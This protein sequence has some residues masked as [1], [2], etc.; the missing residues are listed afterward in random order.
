M[1]LLVDTAV[2]AAAA[3]LGRP[4]RSALTSLGIALGVTAL[5]AM[6]GMGA[7]SAASIASEFEQLQ[8]TRVEVS[9]PETVPELMASL[10]PGGLQRAADLNGVRAVGVVVTSGDRPVEV[11]QPPSLQTV[12]VPLIAG[13]GEMLEAERV[14]VVAGRS[15]DAGHQ[16]RGDRVALLGVIAARRVGLTPDRLPSQLRVGHEVFV[17]GGIVDSPDPASL[18]PEAVVVPLSSVS[19]SALAEDLG[20]PTVVFR[21]EL[22]AADHVGKEAALALDPEQPRL[23]SAAVPPRPVLLQAAVEGR[24]RVQL[25]AVAFVS[26]IVGA[27][28][29]SNTTLVGVMERRKEIGVRRAVGAGA[30]VI[31]AQFLLESAALGVMG[32]LVGGV[33]GI[34][35][36]LG[37]ALV[38]GWHLVLPVWLV[39]LGPALGAGVGVVAG[40]YPAYRASRVEPVEA[41]RA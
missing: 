34:S 27:I 19:G 21:T 9:G 36:A 25:I 23:L 31:V 1:T 28:G 13:L 4:M 22:G 11:G 3:V 30:G 2:E 37:A 40:A 14:Q 8:A 29:V 10:G 18:V 39:V 26:I 6:I 7:S 33:L 38:N 15:F 17:V 20:A 24:T 12:Q 5:T 35:T 41:L 16:A 32:G